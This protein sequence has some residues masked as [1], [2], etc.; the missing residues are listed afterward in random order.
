M[1]TTILESMCI[2]TY[3]VEYPIRELRSVFSLKVQGLTVL[4]YEIR[5]HLKSS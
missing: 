5:C 3:L 4:G 1:K 2:L